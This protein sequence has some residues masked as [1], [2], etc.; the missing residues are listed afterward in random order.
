MVV[1][2]EADVIATGAQDLLTLERAGTI[3]IV[4]AARLLAMLG[5]LDSTLNDQ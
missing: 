2:G 3:P 1:V 5:S 4:T